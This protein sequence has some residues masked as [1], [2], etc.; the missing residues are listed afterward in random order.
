[1]ARIFVLATLSFRNWFPT[2]RFED[3]VGK[4]SVDP[5]H[6]AAIFLFFFFLFFF[7]V[8]LSC[9]CYIDES[10]SQNAIQVDFN[11]ELSF[12]DP[13]VTLYF[14]HTGGHIEAVEIIPLHSIGDIIIIFSCLRCQQVSY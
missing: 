5:L 14:A 8:L 7:F 12:P 10:I 4:P 11:E 2:K 13:L 3:F 6:L 9:C 1:M